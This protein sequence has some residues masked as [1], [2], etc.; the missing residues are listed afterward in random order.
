[1]KRIDPAT[2]TTLAG[3]FRERITLTP[4]DPAYRYFDTENQTWLTLNWEAIAKKVLCW[5]MLMRETGLKQGDRVAI[6]LPNCPEWVAIDQA[7]LGLG[8]VVVPLYINDRGGN[9][10]YI[11]NDCAAGLLVI[12][13]GG[14]WSEIAAEIESCVDLKRVVTLSRIVPEPVKHGDMVHAAYFGDIA[15]SE[16][17]GEWQTCPVG[18]GDLASIVYT[19][20][21]TGRPKGV[22][23][24]H[25]NILSNAHACSLCADVGS[26]DLFLSFLPLSHTF[27]RTVG[28]YLPVMLGAEVAFAR[29]ILQLAEDLLTIRPTVMVSVPRIYERV[30]GRIKEQMTTKPAIVR[31]LF[32]RAVSIGW[33]RQLHEQGR[34]GWTPAFLFW[35]ILNRLVA[36]KVMARLGGRIKV[37]VCGG[38]PL[39]SEISK[40]FIALGLPLLNGYG[41]TEASPVVSVNR[42]D[43]NHPETVGKVLDRVEV[44]LGQ[45]DELL[46]RG[47]GV[48]KGYWHQEEATHQVID[49]DGWLH[50][51][52]QAAIDYEGRITITG[53]LKEIIVLAN[54][55]KVPP[56]DMELA[57]SIDPLFEQVMVAGEQRP[58]L[59][60]L[61]VPE[62]THW[63]QFC[64][65]QGVLDTE[66]QC[67]AAIT[68]MM[69]ERVSRHLSLFPG[70]AQVRQIAI[71]LD[72]WT[73][74]N[75]LLTP[76]LKLR[77]KQM[78][79][80]FGPRIE[81]LYEGH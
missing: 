29:S 48:M 67:P 68:E 64:Q 13:G 69:I 72:P 24:S 36:A 75:G 37:A 5:Q 41:M 4:E 22:M 19:S 58:F 78:M 11:L 32:D 33:R 25:E 45:D 44:T 9:I 43:D 20:G 8:L 17:Q 27:E 46:V 61:I 80:R 73:V 56:A 42:V 26:D 30:Y 76:T 60:A 3:L 1:M 18:P 57:I 23:L 14:E 66:E 21:T 28:Y 77:R 31:W 15:P 50:T 12:S 74:E 40:T 62:P 71:C 2:A 55:E 35:P 49:D 47:P 51:G 38:A 6:M 16:G 70:Y 7:A 81:A 52:D 65:E 54:G 34:S 59:V 53:R 10:A 79:S 39:S 63:K